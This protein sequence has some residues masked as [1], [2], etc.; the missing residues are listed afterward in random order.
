MSVRIVARVSQQPAPLAPELRIW[1]LIGITTSDNHYDANRSFSTQLT[2]FSQLSSLREDCVRGACRSG[3][4]GVVRMRTALLLLSSLSATCAYALHSRIPPMPPQPRAAS[5]MS[6]N[7]E[8]YTMPRCRHCDTAK[9]FLASQGVAYT[10]VDVT[11]DPL[12]LPTMMVRT[13]GQ[14]TVPQIFVDDKLIGG[15][16]DML[17]AADAGSL[18]L[19]GVVTPTAQPPADHEAYYSGLTRLLAKKG[20]PVPAPA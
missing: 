15:C 6:S 10:E 20:Q 11:A 19:R 16:S 7:I 4:S 17:E 13:K 12:N 14:H 3:A 8:V 18:E 5:A 9:D 2:R 1:I